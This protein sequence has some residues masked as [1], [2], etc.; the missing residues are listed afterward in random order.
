[1]RI[2]AYSQVQQIYKAAQADKTQKKAN[3]KASDQL[4]LSSLGKEYQ[5]AKQAVAN[6]ADVREELT[7]PLKKSIQAGTYEVSAEQF[8]DK[9]LQKYEEMR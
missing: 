3:I 6:S 4:E 5:T 9:L 1:M 2:E 7:A 8:A